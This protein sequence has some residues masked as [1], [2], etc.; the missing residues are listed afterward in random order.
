MHISVKLIY[1]NSYDYLI[2]L[3][4]TVDIS[5]VVFIDGKDKCNIVSSGGVSEIML[6]SWVDKSFTTDPDWQD[7]NQAVQA[8]SW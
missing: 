4:L 3:K 8:R 1:H 6:C 5:W 2:P 7:V